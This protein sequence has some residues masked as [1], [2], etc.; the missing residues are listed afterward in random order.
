MA[1][2]PE[3]QRF[4]IEVRQAVPTASLA[5]FPDGAVFADDG[6][7]LHFRSIDP[8]EQILAFLAANDTDT[9]TDPDI[10]AEQC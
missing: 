7:D 9:D 3:I 10:E 8:G 1:V 4:G 2:P 5:F 6:G